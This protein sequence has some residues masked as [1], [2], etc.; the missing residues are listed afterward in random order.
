VAS[1]W[2]QKEGPSKKIKEVYFN[3]AAAEATLVGG[4]LDPRSPRPPLDGEETRVVG[5]GS[6]GGAM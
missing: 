3:S 2:N 1:V 4:Q 6:K 5:D